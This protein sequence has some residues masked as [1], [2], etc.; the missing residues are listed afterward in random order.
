[1]PRAKRSLGQNFLVDPNLQRKIVDALEAGPGDEVLEIGPGTGALTRHL[2]GAVRRLVAIELDDALVDALRQEFGGAPG[3]AI[4]HANALE[5]D[6][7]ALSDDVAR[8]KVVGN[9]PYNITTPLIFWLL[10]RPVRPA[11]IVLMIQKEVAGRILAEPG[12]KSYGALSVGVRAV[13]AV[14]RLFT[15]GR[16]AFRPVPDVD[17]AVI[18]ITPFHPSPLSADEERD[19]RALTRAAF[20]W[21]RKQIQ[22]ILR[23]A[24]GYGLDAAAVAAAGRAAG[25]DVYARPETLDP[26]S[27]IRLARALRAAGFPT[28]PGPT[29]GEDAAAPPHGPDTTETE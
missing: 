17:S 9:I 29:G 3:V 25:V 23:S 24:P 4:V 14:E 13:A 7:D 21:R 10:E 12:G 2:A 27:F 11:R 19:L 18:R 6:L 26:E 8:L 15:V 1:M 20:A 16:G 28:D 5:Q 22:K